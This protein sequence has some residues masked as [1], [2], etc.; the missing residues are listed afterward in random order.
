MSFIYFTHVKNSE[1]MLQKS[2]VVVASANGKRLEGREVG[3]GGDFLFIVL[4]CTIC[5]FLPNTCI[6]LIKRTI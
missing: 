4:I 1:K 5:M 2:L 3:S 6:F